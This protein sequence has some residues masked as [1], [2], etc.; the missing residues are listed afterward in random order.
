MTFAQSPIRQAI[1]HSR[2]ERLIARLPES[3]EQ[4]LQGIEQNLLEWSH[5]RARCATCAYLYRP[6][7][8]RCPTCRRR[9]PNDHPRTNGRHQHPHHGAVAG[10]VLATASALARPSIASA[11]QNS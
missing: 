8:E 11:S 6:Y 10:S 3:S 4:H 2:I 1:T 9:T 7:L 5:L